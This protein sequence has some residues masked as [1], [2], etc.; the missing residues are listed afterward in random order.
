M[1]TQRFQ[2]FGSSVCMNAYSTETTYFSP[3]LNY[4]LEKIGRTA[5]QQQATINNPSTNSTSPNGSNNSIFTNHQPLSFEM[6]GSFTLHVRI[7]ATNYL[8]CIL[9]QKP[10]I[11]K[12]LTL[13]I[14][15]AIIETFARLL[16]FDPDNFIKYFTPNL[17]GVLILCMPNNLPPVSSFQLQ[18]QQQQS[19]QNPNIIQTTFL[20]QQLN[21]LIELIAFRLKH[22]SFTHRTTFLVLL[23][24]LFI[25]QQQQTQQQQPPINYIKHPQIYYK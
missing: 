2:D 15:A 8:T 17:W 23:N 18:Q 4:L 9:I 11:C 6:I 7:H 13:N 19:P 12:I 1:N 5:M 16:I 20:H 21:L 3:P 22:L 14:P 10:Q 24:N 25:P